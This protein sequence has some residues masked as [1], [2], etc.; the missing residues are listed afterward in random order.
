M[1]ANAPFATRPC[2]PAAARLQ[3]G[4]IG[5]FVGG[6]TQFTDDAGARRFR[7]QLDQ[8]LSMPARGQAPNAAP[9]RTDHLKT[10]DEAECICM[11]IVKR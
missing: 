3:D 5:L 1:S 4:R 7:D 8:V 6:E 9:V 10:D 11:G 2:K